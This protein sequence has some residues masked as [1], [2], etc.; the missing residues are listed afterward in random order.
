MAAN[1]T[2]LAQKS[3]KIGFDSS[4]VF[5]KILKTFV[6]KPEDMTLIATRLVYLDAYLK[7]QESKANKDAI[8]ALISLFSDTEENIKRF[9]WNRYRK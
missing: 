1:L 2:S 5:K 7:T 3:A 6:E 9:T 4:R 8:E